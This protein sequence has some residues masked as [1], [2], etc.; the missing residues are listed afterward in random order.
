MSVAVPKIYTTIEADDTTY[1][2]SVDITQAKFSLP[3]TGAVGSF[4]LSVVHGSGSNFSKYNDLNVKKNVSIWLGTG[5][6]GSSP[7]FSGK[8]DTIHSKFDAEGGY[9]AVIEGR[10]L[11][12]ALFRHQVTKDYFGWTVAN[13]SDAV[14]TNSGSYDV[15]LMKFTGS[16]PYNDTTTINVRTADTGSLFHVKPFGF[17]NTSFG[18][19]LPTDIYGTGSVTEFPVSA[20]VSV[21]LPI[22]QLVL[23]IMRSGSAHTG[24]VLASLYSVDDTGSLSNRL[25]LSDWTSGSSIDFSTTPMCIDTINITPYDSI[26]GKYVYLELLWS[27]DVGGSAADAGLQLEWGSKSFLNIPNNDG[28]ATSIVRDL[29]SGSGIVTGSIVVNTTAL[30]PSYVNKTAFSAIKEICDIIQSDFRVN[31]SGQLDLWARQSRT[32]TGSLL[33]TGSNIFSIEKIEDGTNVKNIIAVYGA[34]ESFIPSDGDR[35]TEFD[36][37]G[38]VALTGSII[39]PTGSSPDDNLFP[40]VGSRYLG[41]WSGSGADAGRFQIQHLISPAIDFLTSESPTLEFY[42]S[43]GYARLLSDLAHV[44]LK[45]TSGGGDYFEATATA[46]TSAAN[47]TLN[48]FALG[49]SNVTGSDRSGQW[50]RIGSINWSDIRYVDIEGGIAT[51]DNGCPTVRLDWFHFKGIRWSGSY[52]DE[53]SIGDY[54]TG[55]YSEVSNYFHSD[56]ECQNRATELGLKWKDPVIQYK[57][58]T[59]GSTHLLPGYVTQLQL[60]TEGINNPNNCDILEVTHQFTAPDGFQTDVTLGDSIYVRDISELMDY[61]VLRSYSSKDLDNVARGNRYYR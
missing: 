31:P 9:V 55:S 28:W 47:W 21:Y 6:T 25:Y 29:L 5:A 13:P 59:T 43:I 50:R 19:D 56:G 34:A 45:R 32:I 37:S 40:A 42:L 10:D 49:E 48:S 14:G 18:T 8:S 4:S 33:K 17:V 20:G 15:Y 35:W 7:L 30:S 36:P 24:H 27:V 44:R 41:A 58:L 3:V 51:P 11:G 57:V 54:G 16:I 38:W 12:E 2:G 39:E 46:P 26:S 23:K 61:G 52:R 60:P 22:Y 1:S 53:T